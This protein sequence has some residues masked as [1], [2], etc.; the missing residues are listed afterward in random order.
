MLSAIFIQILQLIELILINSCF[1]SEK[2]AVSGVVQ[3]V[4][5]IDFCMW[6]K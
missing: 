3:K 4:T 6:F 2:E 1:F 5:E